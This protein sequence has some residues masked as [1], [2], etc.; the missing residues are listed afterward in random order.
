MNVCGNCVKFGVEVA[1][2]K[3]E[4]TGRSQVTQSLERRAARSRSKDV[5]DQMEE[6]LK[7][8]YGQIVRDARQR[9]GLTVEQLGEK[10][11]ERVDTLKKVEAGTFHPPDTLVK[12][13]EKELGVKLMEKPEVPAGVGGRPRESPS[14]GFTLGDIIKDAAKKNK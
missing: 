9:R 2:P 14:K 10:L 7:E 3:T 1:G 8:D 12:K 5:F 4:V 6:E 13:L 11:L